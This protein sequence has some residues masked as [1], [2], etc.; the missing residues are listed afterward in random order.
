MTYIK[1]FMGCS[2]DGRIGFHSTE[3][4]KFSSKQDL[5]RIRQE[6]N[7]FDCIFMGSSTLRAY[8][9]ILTPFNKDKFVKYLIY[10][11]S[12]DLNLHNYPVFQKQTNLCPKILLTK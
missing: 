2:L 10:S 11:A 1:A 8:G 3:P 9:S 7:N 4:A 12:G 6:L 5:Q